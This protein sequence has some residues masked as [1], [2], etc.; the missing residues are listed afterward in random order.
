MLLLNEPKLTE[1][2]AN[3][4]ESAVA[5]YRN[6]APV[7]AQFRGTTLPVAVL[8]T[9]APSTVNSIDNTTD[10]GALTLRGRGTA[11]AGLGWQPVSGSKKRHGVTRGRPPRDHHR[12]GLQTKPDSELSR[13]RIPHQGSR[14]FCLVEHQVAAHQ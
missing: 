6:I 4:Y 13:P 12:L 14:P 2:G 1:L 3:A 7:F 11:V 9:T 5:V 8:S 10:M